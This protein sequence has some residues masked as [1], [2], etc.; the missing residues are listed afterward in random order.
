MSV[1]PAGFEPASATVAGSCAPVTP[2]PG[3]NLLTFFARIITVKH[4]RPTFTRFKRGTPPTNPCKILSDAFGAF[5]DFVFSRPTQSATAR[6]CRNHRRPRADPC[7]RRERED[8]RYY[9]PDRLFD[10]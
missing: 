7:W 5:P 8:S 6:G 9:L 2:R 10:R 1:D 4:H 3:G